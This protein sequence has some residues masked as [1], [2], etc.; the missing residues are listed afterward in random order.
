MCGKL[1]KVDTFLGFEDGV[2]E[3]LFPRVYLLFCLA[4][5]SGQTGVAGF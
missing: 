5:V 3:S 4:V 1:C 2:I